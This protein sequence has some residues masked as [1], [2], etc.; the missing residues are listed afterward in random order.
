MPIP[1]T[2]GS[3]GTKL[4]APDSAAGRKVKCPKCSTPVAVPNGVAAAPAAASKTAGKAADPAG[5]AKAAPAPAAEAATKRR[6]AATASAPPRP[7]ENGSADAGLLAQDRWMIRKKERGLLPQFFPLRFDF[8]RP[9]TKELIGYVTERVSF[10]G[11][12]LRGFP[13]F[14]YQIPTRYEVTDA[15]GGPVLFTVRNP[16]SFNFRGILFGLVNVTTEVWDADNQL[17]GSFVFNPRFFNKG[18]NFT[19]TDPQGKKMGEFRFK[20][21]EFRP[22]KENVPSR[23]SLLSLQGQEWGSITGEHEAEMMQNLK[24][25]QEGKKKFAF[26]FQF[27][28]PP[29]GMLITVNPEAPDQ[30]LAKILLL[31]AAVSMKRFKATDEMFQRG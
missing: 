20:M 7:A 19:L 2:C 3:C 11:K 5:P 22:G 10:W 13:R 14:H 25:F 30:R 28:P 24:D 23:M 27:L 1:V 8:F 18:P 17:I 6:P 4:K 16:G 9:G 26:R 12:L 21:G 15:E 29:P 31:S